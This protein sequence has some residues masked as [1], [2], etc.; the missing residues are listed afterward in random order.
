VPGSAHAEMDLLRTICRAFL[1]PYMY[2]MDETG[3]YWRW[4]ICKGL[5]TASLPGVKKDKARISMAL[6]S[7]GTGT[8]KLPL[9][10]IGKSKMPHALRGVNIEAL[11]LR[12]RAS[13]KAWMTAD[14]MADWLGAF[15][16]HVGELEVILLMDNF[17]AHVA[18]IE[19]APPPSNVRI[20]FLPKNSTSQYQPLDQGV[21]K[22]FKHYYRKLWLRFSINCYERKQD[23]VKKVTLYDALRW[24]SQAWRYQVSESTIH[25]CWS[26]S[27]LVDRDDPPDLIP[28][29]TD[30]VELLQLCQEV[31]EVA[32][33]AREPESFIYPE[34]EDDEPD[35]PVDLQEIIDHHVDNTGVEVD[36]LEADEPEPPPSIADAMKALS[37]VQ[38]WVEHQDDATINDTALLGQLERSMQ[39]KAASRRKQ[40]TLNGWILTARDTLDRDGPRL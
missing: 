36:P 38:N 39:L 21:I 7:N 35:E 30:L 25:R 31:A 19:L 17:R 29:P 4:A 12:W 5:A 26:K 10:T 8:D 33:D 18:A 37:I 9:W 3:L 6:C 34:G 20:E 28:E 2:N 11:G 23:P 13:A 32:D 15:Y 22:K 16:K 24:A 1:A 27:T 40:T 14:I